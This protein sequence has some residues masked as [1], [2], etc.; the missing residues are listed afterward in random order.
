M[1]A[2]KFKSYIW[3]WLVSAILTLG[4]VGL[5]NYIVDPYG[6]YRTVEITGFNQQKEGVRSKIRYV[7]AMELPLRKPQTVI[8]GSSRVHDGINPQ[9][10]LLLDPAYSPSYNLGIDMD[11]VHESLE[12]L[13]HAI[14]NSKIKRVIFGLDFFMFNASQKVNYNFDPELVGRKVTIG[15]YVKTSIF[16]RDAFVDSIRTIKM[17]HSQ[18]ERK[19]F[20]DNGFRPGNFVF[21]RVKN[22]SALHYYTNYIFM[23]SLPSQT[24]YYADMTIDKEVFDDFEEILKI[25]KQ[26]NINIM[27]YIS[28]AHAHLDGEGIA[29]SGKWDM[30]EDW[31][32]KIV[33]I[34]EKYNAPLWDFSGYNSIT[35][36]QVKTPMKYYWDSSHFTEVVSDLILKRMLLGRG[37]DIPANFGIRL[38]NQNIELHLAAIREDRQKYYINHGPD[39][40]TLNQSYRAFLK[41][42]ELDS[43]KIE[44]M[45]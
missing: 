15:D 36:E 4:M 20:L 8:I 26:N 6:L 10:P 5:F 43:T 14:V 41:G 37:D 17:S 23:S 7:K 11:R 19:E 21:Y 34:S 1:T 13:K 25:C 22:Y 24:K 31:K 12:Y 33:A 29:A 27:L 35:T 9:H 40:D 18:P 39:V 30:M 32:R 16:S 44:G 42:G 3:V 2:H 28:P 38:S 45:F